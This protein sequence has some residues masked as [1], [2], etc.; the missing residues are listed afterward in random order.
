MVK[1]IDVSKWVDENLNENLEETLRYRSTRMFG[2][3][4]NNNGNMTRALI[5]SDADPYKLL[6]RWPEDNDFDAV[7]LVMTGWMS[8]IND[9]DDDEDAEPIKFRV[10]VVAS[11]NDHGVSVVVRQWENDD[12]DESQ[13]F[14]DGGEGLFPE[15]LTAWW[16]AFKSG[17][18][19]SIDNPAF[20]HNT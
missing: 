10:R 20:W 12:M 5:D 2:I 6:T 18:R 11:V 9:E 1:P 14:E 17:V 8:R 15:A 16:T 7:S 3:K 4:V 13:S 19:P